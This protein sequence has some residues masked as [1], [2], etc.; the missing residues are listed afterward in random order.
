MH[1][2]GASWS[3]NNFRI[4]VQDKKYFL[5][6][7]PSVKASWS[8]GKT[9]DETTVYDIRKAG[10]NYKEEPYFAMIAGAYVASYLCGIGK[11]HAEYDGLVGT[12]AR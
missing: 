2:W 12:V 3:F 6:R 10:F 5:A 9:I 7:L 1:E 11:Q 4:Y 8:K